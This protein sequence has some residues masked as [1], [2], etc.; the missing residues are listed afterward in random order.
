M[1]STASLVNEHR[2]RIVGAIPEAD[3]S[4]SG[5]ASIEGLVAN[6]VDLVALV[7]NVAEAAARLRRLYPPL[8]EEEWRE[9]WAAFRDEGPPQVDLVVTQLGTKGDAHHRRAWEL[10]AQNA[11]L[12]DEY[13]ALKAS[14]DDYERRKAAFFERL[15]S[16]LDES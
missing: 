10:L 7:P 11:D 6:D 2:R 4:L 16:L 8:F 1:D 3:V 14:D 5:G 13:R 15:V 9:D 12:L